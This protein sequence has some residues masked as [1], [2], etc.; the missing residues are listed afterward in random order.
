MCVTGEDGE[1]VVVKNQRAA[2]HEFLGDRAFAVLD[3]DPS[4]EELWVEIIHRDSECACKFVAPKRTLT[5]PAHTNVGAVG[6]VL[7]VVMGMDG[8]EG[9]GGGGDGFCCCC[10]YGDCSGGGGHGGGGDGA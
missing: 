6:V 4:T 3:A 1:I 2:G 9:G 8:E 5:R 10:C 7:I